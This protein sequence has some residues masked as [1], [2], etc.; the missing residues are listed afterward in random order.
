MALLVNAYDTNSCSETRL[1]S[2]RRA[3]VK[4]KRADTLHSHE[5]TVL[6]IS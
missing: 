2:S 5:Q 4:Y 6:I 3:T 1:W